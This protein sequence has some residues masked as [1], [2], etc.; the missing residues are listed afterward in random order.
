MMAFV[1]LRSVVILKGWNSGA[2]EIEEQVYA[3]GEIGAV[4]EADSTL[5]NVCLHLHQFGIPSRGTDEHVFPGSYASRDVIEH[6]VWRSE[7]DNH[8]K[9]SQARLG[10]SGCIRIVRGPQDFNLLST[11][12]RNLCHERASFPTAQQEN[13]HVF[14]V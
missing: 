9:P 11:L 5:L 1:N 10:Q 6:A 2:H 12:P 7:L 3:D 8:V 14:L 4:Q 13:L